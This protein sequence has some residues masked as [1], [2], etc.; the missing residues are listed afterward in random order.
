MNQFVFGD[1]GVQL[2]C[3]KFNLVLDNLISGFTYFESFVERNIVYRLASMDPEQFQGAQCL[4]RTGGFELLRL[5]GR[6][7]LM[8][9]WARLRFGYGIWLEDLKGD[10]E[11]PVWVNPKINDETPLAVTRLLSTIGLH[12]KLLQHGLPVLHA[13]YIEFYGSGIIFTAPSGVGK[14]TQAALW[15]QFEGAEIIN[16]DRVL[17][18]K[19]EGRWYAHGYPC[20]GSSL[21]CV[22]R[23]SPL[24]AIVVL[25]QGKKNQVDMLSIPQKI[26]ALSSATEIYIWDS[27]EIEHAI[28]TAEEIAS[29]VPIVRLTCTPDKNAVDTLKQY[30]EG[31]HA[32]DFI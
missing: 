20:C 11:I 18:G 26:R 29:H 31:M 16:G 3:E 7:F 19:K 23:S 8:N 22:N 32:D 21:I 4:Q 13:S 25:E 9:H 17:L 5:N 2:N 14:S 30:L 10:M 1:I 12:S 28:S 27:D 6:L 24:A 15:N